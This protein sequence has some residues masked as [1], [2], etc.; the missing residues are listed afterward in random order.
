MWCDHLDDGFDTAFR[1]VLGRTPSEEERQLLVD[2]ITRPV[3]SQGS[4]QASLERWICGYGTFNPE[5]N[6]LVDFKRLPKF[7]GATWQGGDALPDPQLGWSFLNPVGGHPGNDLQHVVSKRWIAPRDGKLRIHG[8]LQHKQDAGDGVR[9]TVL[10]NGGNSIGQWTA[11]N[12]EAQTDSVLMFVFAGQDIDF[13]TDC[14]G[15]PDSDGFSWRVRIRYEDGAREEFDAEKQFPALPAAPLDRWQ[16]LA[17][18]L[19][20]SNEFAFVD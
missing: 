18:A 12:S 8:Q 4:E 2:F 13:V 19:L 1:K 20:A 5:T 11:R 10:V 15:G 17:Q 9:A 16:Q 6:T 14:I 7:T 3:A